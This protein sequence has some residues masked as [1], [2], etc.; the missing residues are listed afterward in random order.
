MGDAGLD[1]VERRRPAPEPFETANILYSIDGQHC[2]ARVKDHVLKAVDDLHT[3]RAR[4][5]GVPA[6]PE[7]GRESSAPKI[8]IVSRYHFA[9]RPR[10]DNM[11]SVT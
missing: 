6:G 1:V 4:W 11:W 10:V 9:R 7:V 5:L 8:I 2:R 3:A